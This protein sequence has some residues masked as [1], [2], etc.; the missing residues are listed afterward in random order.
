M[1]AVID[2]FNERVKEIELYFRFLEQLEKPEVSLYFPRQKTHKYK[3]VE[4]DV[5]KMLKASVF[6]VIY[7]LVESS[8]RDGILEL[9]RQIETSRCTYESVRK[10]IRDIWIDHNYKHISKDTANWKSAK[11]TAARLVE[12]AINHAILQLDSEAIPISGNLDARQIRRVCDSHGISHHSH[13]SAKGGEKLLE[14]KD[15]RNKLAHGHLSFSECG[16]EFTIN[17]LKEIKHQ[18]VIFVRSILRNMQTYV[19]RK[20]YVAVDSS[21]AS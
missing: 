11:D 7:N 4:P 14:V 18:T 20:Q 8:I 5:F 15:Q 16:R 9:Y 2:T 13:P 10:E 6:L 21:E 12:E 3:D 1:K 19:N 17:A